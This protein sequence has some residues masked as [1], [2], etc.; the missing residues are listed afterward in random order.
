MSEEEKK[1][2]E[3]A[4][5]GKTKQ[6]PTPGRIAL[7]RVNDGTDRAMLIVKVWNPNVVNGII[8]LDG[9]NDRG[10]AVTGVREG[11]LHCHATS[12]VRGHEVNQW[13][14]YDE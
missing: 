13:R 8:F 7:V 11:S 5:S 4:K 3:P 1:Q 9:W 6:V 12:L 10:L 2:Q 14:F